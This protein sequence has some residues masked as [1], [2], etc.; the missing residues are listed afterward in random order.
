MTLYQI[1]DRE[2]LEYHGKLPNEMLVMNRIDIHTKFKGKVEGHFV[3]E[4]VIISPEQLKK[5]KTVQPEFIE[6][7]YLMDYSGSVY[8]KSDKSKFNLQYQNTN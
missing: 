7:N 1:N 2:Y 4:C 5:I 3:N 8:P 6:I